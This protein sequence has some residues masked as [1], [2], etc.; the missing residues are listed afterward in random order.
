MIWIGWGGK[1]SHRLTWGIHQ[2][3][4]GRGRVAVTFDK[5]RI[6]S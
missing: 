2:S 1:R 5:K 3:P 4:D 6:T